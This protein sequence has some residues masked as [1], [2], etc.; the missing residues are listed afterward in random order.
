MTVRADGSRIRLEGDC[1]VEDAE[2]LLQLLHATPEAVADL[3]DCRRLHAA[4]LQVLLSFRVPLAA[5]PKDEALR[6]HVT[7]SLRLSI[8][9]DRIR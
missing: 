6:A 7:P 9:M 2:A 3:S 1:R 8:D 4:V 5:E